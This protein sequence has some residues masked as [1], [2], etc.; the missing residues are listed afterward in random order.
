MKLLYFLIVLTACVFPCKSFSQKSILQ[1]DHLGTVD[2]LSQSNVLCILQDSRGFMWFGT[3]DGLN[4]YDGYKF[5]V[6]KHDPLNFKSI[7][8]NYIINISESKNGDI[9]IAAG[10]GLCRYNRNTENFTTYRNDPNNPN[11]LCND[12]INVVKQD[13]KGMIWIGTADGL[14]IY[15]PLRNKFEHFTHTPSDES[16]LSD[17][18]IRY[19]F[20]DTDQNMWICTLNGGLNLFNSKTRSFTHF[21]HYKKDS[22]S[23]SSNN[24]YTMFEDSRQ[25]LWVG[26][27]GAGLNLFNK[28]EGTFVHFAHDDNN[29]NTLAANS[30]YA[31][32]EDADNNLWIGTENGGLS[33]L[34]Y[35]TGIFQTYKN[36]A[37]NRGSISNNSIYS[38]YKDSKNNMWL[39]NFADGIDLVSRDKTRFSHFTHTLLNNSLSDNHVLSI[40]E[41]RAKNIW[42]G[43]DGGGLDLFDPRTGN[44]KNFRHHKNNNQSICGNYVL[45]TCEDSKGNIWIGTWA[46]GVTV[47]NP[48]KNTYKHFKNEPDN[49]SS[50]SSNNIW[51]IY[52]DRE[53]NIWLG[54][55]GGGL[56]L[57]NP[58]GKSFTNYKYNKNY[59]D[60]ISSNEVVSFLEDS[61]GLMWV[62]T[63]D[64]G[65]NLF[66]KKNKTFSHF[67]HDAAKNSI[68][69]NSV[70]SIYEGS[71]KNLWIGT[72]K[73]LSCFNK[74][75]GRFMVYTTADGLPD[76]SI[77]GILEDDKKNL[78]ISTNKGISCFNPSTRV[79]KNFGVSDGLQSNEFKEKAFCKS[80]TGMMYFGGIN[81]FNQ[82]FPSNIQPVSF[83]P[84]LVITSFQ[85][86]NN[87]VPIA[88]GKEHPSP[89]LK[90][91][92]ETKTITLPYSSS[93][94]SLEFASLNYTSREKKRYAYMLEGFDKTWNESGTARIATYTNL[95]PGKYI[96]KVKGLNNAGHWSSNMIALEII[97]KPPFWLTWW[98]RMA[99][100]VAFAGSIVAFYK[101]RVHT[102]KA[103]KKM[104]E[105]KVRQQTQLLLVSAEDEQRARKA[106]EK[107]MNETRLLNNEL[108]I[109]NKELEQ[110]AYVASHDLQEP[111]RTTSSFVALLQKQYLGKMD[112]RADK[113]LNYISDASDRMKVLIKDLLDYSRIGTKGEPEKIDSN[114]I[115]S[116]VLHDLTVATEEA[117]AEI[118]YQHLPE[119]NGYP[120]E[121]KLLF[122]N[123][124][125]NAIKFRKKDVAPQ[126]TINAIQVNGDWQFVFRD[127]G[128]GI[129]KENNEKIF[130]IFQRL[131]T[132]TEYEGSGIG[133]SHCKKIVEL[134]HGKIWVES[135]PGEGSAF[136][137]TIPEKYA[138]KGKAHV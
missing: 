81:G 64:G 75:T 108:R 68:S 134:H 94:F 32:N 1:F 51:K 47:Y 111:L 86:F 117:N 14:D 31:L 36:D 8:G 132:R 110:F 15:D 89:L 6:Y 137:F 59:A 26:T 83:E 72:R 55:F 60:G 29:P 109:K 127:N 121:I 124:V 69:N 42:I 24:I 120:T 130:H 136:Y 56:S 106:A 18:D 135:V 112:D 5:T 133:L 11:S 10:E 103:Q 128:I 28:K 50:L 22:R 67:L 116:N 102:I 71:D 45:T 7:A 118:R 92:T 100:L 19:I 93:M 122:Q 43:T 38:I 17:A 4:K 78:W 96:F 88:L 58:D 57:L 13:S 48:S 70:N 95:D 82:F 79:F 90:S 23:I 3:A 84:R 87:T 98:F 9:W 41:D 101:Y 52:E 113:Y 33:I 105:K 20:E 97:I 46:N 66:D 99:V 76:N 114:K 62:G 138:K 25:R 49:S 44:F 30:V 39:G 65:L 73:G 104:L 123:L 21:K 27:D 129:A 91:I 126:I 119:I 35:N 125:I 63:E 131:H 115:L 12:I 80:S 2:G 54:T 16:T 85:I 77:Y 37:I 40:Y 61:D 107:A 34:N 53:K 74:R